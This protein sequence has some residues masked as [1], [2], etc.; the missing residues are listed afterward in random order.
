[1]KVVDIK[2]ILVPNLLIYIY[3]HCVRSSSWC[4][5]MLATLLNTSANYFIPLCLH[6]F[7]Q[8]IFCF[9]IFLFS[10]FILFPFRNFLILMSYYIRYQILTGFF[11]VQFLQSL[12]L[13]WRY[14]LMLTQFSLA[15]SASNL[16]LYLSNFE[17]FSLKFQGT[18]NQE[19]KL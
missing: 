10:R 1:M 4:T 11:L 2:K 6:L 5:T 14:F 13:L 16:P 3:L 19:W 17:P 12:D 9:P 18:N 15:V 7:S 8:L